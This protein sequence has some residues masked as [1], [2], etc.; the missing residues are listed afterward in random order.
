MNYPGFQNL[1]IL[2]LKNHC[3]IWADKD[4]AAAATEGRAAINDIAGAF[5][6]SPVDAAWLRDKTFRYVVEHHVEYSARCADHLGHQG[7]LLQRAA[8]HR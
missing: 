8:S 1:T 3:V 7:P 6:F 2:G 5:E 4:I